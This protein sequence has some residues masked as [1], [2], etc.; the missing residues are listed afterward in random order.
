MKEY[1]IISP[2]SEWSYFDFLNSFKA[3][4]KIYTFDHYQLNYDDFNKR[5][6]A[7]SG[8]FTLHL[9]INLHSPNTYALDKHLKNEINNE[10]TL[11]KSKIFPNEDVVLNYIDIHPDAANEIEQ[12]LLK[13]ILPLKPCS[14]FNWN[15]RLFK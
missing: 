7:Q 6:K 3:S 11:N 12:N 1:K 14:R 9:N 8:V 5:I 15:S 10:K 13:K 2:L 4:N